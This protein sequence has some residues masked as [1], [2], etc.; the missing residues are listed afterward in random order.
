MEGHDGDSKEEKEARNKELTWLRVTGKG[1][2]A[3]DVG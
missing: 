3:D 2:L 1:H